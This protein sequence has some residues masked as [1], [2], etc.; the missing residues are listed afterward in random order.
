MVLLLVTSWWA[1]IG[2]TGTCKPGAGTRRRR[3]SGDEG[4][5]KASGGGGHRAVRAEAGAVQPAADA[6]QGVE[7]GTDPVGGEV[8]VQR[9]HRGAGVDADQVGGN[10]GAV[11][12]AEAVA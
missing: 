3:R 6:G 11:D 5:V 10:P 1:V 8:V 9:Q 12:V 7:A 2:G 4:R